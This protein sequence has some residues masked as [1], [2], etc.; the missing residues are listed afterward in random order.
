MSHNCEHEHEHE[1]GH[2]HSPPLATTEAQSLFQHVDTPHVLCL[3]AVGR[4]SNDLHAC[5]IK[6]QEDRYDVSKYLESDADCQM[7]IHIPFT[8]VCRVYSCL[9]RF[10]RSN[11]G[12]GSPKTVKV[13]KNF[14]KSVDFDSLADAKPQHE[15]ENPENV[16]IDVNGETSVDDDCGYV[17]HN[18]P[19][20]HFQNVESLT[21]FIENNWSD[22][23]D[24]LARCFYLELR[25]EATGQKQNNDGIPLLAVYE[26][27]PNP[28]DHQRVEDDAKSSTLGI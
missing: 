10:S 25:G 22:D 2:D 1:H 24:D 21:F 4:G 15:L 9:F 8:C 23:E 20:Q 14:K 7:I 12:I 26:S 19:R 11:T 28:L 6:S 3:N 27:A 5:F 13:F 17:E 18:L 16:G